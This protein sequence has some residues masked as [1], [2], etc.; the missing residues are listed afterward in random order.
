MFIL[1][2]RNVVVCLVPSPIRVYGKF[3]SCINFSFI[4]RKLINLPRLFGLLSSS[5]TT[6]T[7]FC[8]MIYCALFEG[9]V[10]CSVEE[11]ERVDRFLG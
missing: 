2:A 8:T 5:L 6:V 10:V 1:R 3:N 4:L 11:S 7:L 9:F